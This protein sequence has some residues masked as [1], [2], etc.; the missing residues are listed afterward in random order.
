MFF[1][2]ESTIKILLLDFPRLLIPSTPARTFTCEK[3]RSKCAA[4]LIADANLS[5]CKLITIQSAKKTSCFHIPD[6]RLASA[7]GEPLE[8][9][10]PLHTDF[11]LDRYSRGFLSLGNQPSVISRHSRVLRSPSSFFDVSKGRSKT[12]ASAF[13]FWIILNIL[14]CVPSKLSESTS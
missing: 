5:L 3:G 14:A 12:K 6:A 13:I 4:R 8:D 2:E 9:T 10:L 1:S 11:L 7:S